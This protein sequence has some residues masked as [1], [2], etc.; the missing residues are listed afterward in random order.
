MRPSLRRISAAT[1]VTRQS[2]AGHATKVDW[3]RRLRMLLRHVWL[4]SIAAALAV[5]GSAAVAYYVAS[6]P[7]RLKIAV[8][9]PDSDDVRAV[10]AI[11]NQLKRERSN[12]RLQMIIKPGGPVEAAKAIDSGETELAVVR[13]DLGLPKNGAAVAILRKNVV[14]LFVPA[15]VAEPG[16]EKAK[17]EAAKAKA[18][19][20]TKAAGK[21]KP[22]AKKS[23]VAK[24]AKDEDEDD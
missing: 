23:K 11:A 3:S 17:P 13:Q 6:Q 18:P 20:K 14:V 10:E 4:L 7:T 9:P 16:K 19:A 12:F 22:A 2:K 5:C 1:V 24:T 15:A 8:G 21:E